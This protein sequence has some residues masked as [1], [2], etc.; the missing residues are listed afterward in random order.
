[1]NILIVTEVFYPENF[2]VNDFAQ[3]MVKRGHHVKV[4]TR[5]PSYPQG[6]VFEG[7]SN[8]KYSVEK[9]GEIEIH[10]FD[11]IEGY[12]DS[13]IKKIANYYHYVQRGKEVIND[14]YRLS[15]RPSFCSSPSHLC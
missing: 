14:H 7:Y 13:K 1:M 12:R 2:H 10:R 3:A 8:Q 9:W 15:N 4:M 5:Q 6:H 11:V